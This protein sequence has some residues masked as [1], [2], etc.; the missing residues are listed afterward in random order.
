ME[1]RAWTS[2]Q[3]S[4]QTRGEKTAS[5]ERAAEGIDLSLAFTEP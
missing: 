3:A 5:P 1:V 4:C 2:A